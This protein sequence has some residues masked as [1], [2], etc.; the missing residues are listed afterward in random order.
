MLGELGLAATRLPEVAAAIKL[1]LV[2]NCQRVPGVDA[3]AGA[4]RFGSGWAGV[5]LL[6]EEAEDMKTM[7]DPL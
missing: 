7:V 1:A 6:W 3:G 4:G 5:F 2:S